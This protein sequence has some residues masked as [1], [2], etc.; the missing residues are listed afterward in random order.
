MSDL[1]EPKAPPV[2][3]R[4]DLGSHCWLALAKHMEARL[5]KLRI[6]NDSDLDSVATA[7]VRGQIKALLNVLAL[8]NPAPALV[9]DAE[10][11]E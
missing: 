7:H 5:A 9:A 4:E 8:A 1:T 10:P 6:K 11:G 2:L 3:S